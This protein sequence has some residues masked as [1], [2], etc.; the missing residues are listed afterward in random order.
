MRVLLC[1]VLTAFTVA[2]C[3]AQESFRR[4]HTVPR[5]PL[6]FESI[7]GPRG[8]VVLSIVCTKQG[9][10]LAG[11]SLN[12]V[13]RSTD[14]GDSW[15]Q[16]SLRDE[17]VWP[18]YVTPGG[19]I[20]AFL[21]HDLLSGTDVKVSTDGGEN[22]TLLPDSTR[23]FY[24]R[25][26]VRTTDGAMYSE[27]GG[28]LHRSTDDGRSWETLQR[29]PPMERCDTD[30][31]LVVLN[32]SVLFAKCS[33]GLFRSGDG[34]KNWLKLPLQHSSFSEL[35]PD[36][37]GGVLVLGT[38]TVG[39][40]RDEVLRIAADGVDIEVFPVS[41]WVNG[42]RRFA[43]L[44]DGNMLMGSASRQEGIIRSMDSAK[45]WMP[46]SVSSGAVHDF[47]QAPD[48]T[49]YAA[50]HGSIYRSF[51]EGLNWEECSNGLAKRSILHLFGDQD[52][53]VYAGT[54]DGGLYSSMDDGRSWRA[55]TTGLCTVHLGLSISPGNL[56]LGTYPAWSFTVYSIEGHHGYDIT[57]PGLD[58]LYTN[59]ST[60]TWRTPKFDSFHPGNLCR[61]MKGEGLRVYGCARGL[62]I[63]DDGGE[64]WRQ[65]RPLEYPRDVYA[66]AMGV[67]ILSD[68]S[69]FLRRS[70]SDT[71]KLLRHGR[72]ISAVGGSGDYVFVYEREAIARS[73]DGGVS[74][75]TVPLHPE[76]PL[77]NPAFVS[78]SSWATV[79]LGDSY[80]L[81]LT[82]NRGR[83]W[84]RIVPVEDHRYRIASAVV[85]QDNYLI[86]GSSEG[87]YRSTHALP[88]SYI[89][90]DFTL[91]I[92]WP[93]PALSNVTI[94]YSLDKD[95]YA[96]MTISDITGR[97]LLVLFEGR[98]N[99]GK[100]VHSLYLYFSSRRP[101]A[102][103]YFVN[104]SVN[105]RTQ[106]QPL[107]L[108]DR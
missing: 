1:V 73:N 50:M 98:R 53:G 81:Y 90:R 12:G 96:R 14:G 42:E 27:G 28:G 95:G 105:G 80:F 67:F 55:T 43:L 64:T 82:S 62:M 49:V 51:D 65:D 68:D 88:G 15:T 87:L 24:G 38:D 35:I 32:D 17:A 4:E 10:L 40:D 19:R 41:S 22:W 5:H 25:A 29:S 101:V 66:N 48:G 47:C 46:T 94:P 91:G 34:G 102:G 107:V 76:Y 39:T 20:L 75:E 21:V 23:K 72:G 13:M 83:S 56:V 58:L 74:W 63:S 59:D 78:V 16:T 71:W 54:Q 92:P 79:L 7:D 70:D 2:W 61:L 93:N 106:T 31:E 18:M 57:T 97:E 52:G 26:V 89:P 6:E 84:E 77:Y 44:S 33:R 11:T 8:E 60:R 36:P 85:D 103:L 100:Y 69:L 86:L 37:A 108:R 30:Y 9:V 104:F 99:A 45:T 3:P